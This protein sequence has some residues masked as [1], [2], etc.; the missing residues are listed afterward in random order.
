MKT[1][2]WAWPRI[3]VLCSGFNWIKVS[4]CES[5]LVVSKAK[6][7]RNRKDARESS[8]PQFSASASI[9]IFDKRFTGW[10]KV[11]E[12]IHRMVYRMSFWSMSLI[13][14]RLTNGNTLL[15]PVRWRTAFGKMCGLSS[16]RFLSLPAPPPCS[17]FFALFCP[18][19]SRDCLAWLEGKGN[20]CYTGYKIDMIFQIFADW[21][22]K[23]FN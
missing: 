8:F 17:Y 12:M 20:D 4:P 15:P 19:P 7:T 11:Y 2:F 18:I 6:Q 22:F 9:F 16:R 3:A 23:W 14:R 10:C 5:S 1:I 13:D 21:A